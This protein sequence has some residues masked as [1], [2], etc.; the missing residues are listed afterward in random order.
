MILIRI[1]DAEEARGRGQGEHFDL[2]ELTS[3]IEEWWL[4]PVAGSPWSPSKVRAQGRR[5]S[6]PLPLVLALARSRGCSRNK[7]S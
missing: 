4:R 7:C 6:P 2:K 3:E 5:E 1:V